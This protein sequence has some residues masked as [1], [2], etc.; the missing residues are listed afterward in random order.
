VQQKRK[1]NRTQKAEKRLETLVAKYVAEGMSADEAKA[2]ALKEMRDNERGDWRAPT[3]L[4]LRS[5]YAIQ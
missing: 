3:S 4:R 5:P 2:K 1:S